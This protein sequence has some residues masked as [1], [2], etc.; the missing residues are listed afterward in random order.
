MLRQAD[1]WKAVRGG[2]RPRPALALRGS[3]EGEAKQGSEQSAP[4]GRPERAGLRPGHSRPGFLPT[5]P[6]RGARLPALCVCYLCDDPA[7]SALPTARRPTGSAL[8]RPATLPS[9]N[10][11]CNTAVLARTWAASSLGFSFLVSAT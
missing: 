10:P 8:H 6:P 3:T 2:A 4:A 11:R 1:R 5:P 9:V 7:L